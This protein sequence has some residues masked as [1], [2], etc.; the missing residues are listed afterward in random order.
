MNS[1]CQHNTSHS[2]LHTL[3]QL[4][5]LTQ[6][7]QLTQLTRLTQ[8][9]SPLG[10][11]SG[12]VLE[13]SARIIV[14]DLVNIGLRRAEGVHHI[15]QHSLDQKTVCGQPHRHGLSAKLSAKLSAT[16]S[17]AVAVASSRC[18]RAEGGCAHSCWYSRPWVSCAAAGSPGQGRSGRC[19]PSY[20]APRLYD[21]SCPL[22]LLHGRQLQ[23]SLNSFTNQK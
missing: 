7:A 1:L 18:A 17:Q 23:P 6:L 2:T 13:E 12:L 21:N 10:A 19:T 5:Q 14:D 15:R 9:R 11:S 8:E 4:T 20:H 16:V 3:T 22:R